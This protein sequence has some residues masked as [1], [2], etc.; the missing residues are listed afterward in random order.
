[1]DEQFVIGLEFEADFAGLGELI[2]VVLELVSR[3]RE[4]RPRQQEENRQSGWRSNESC[5]ASCG[6]HIGVAGS[7]CKVASRLIY[8]GRIRCNITSSYGA[9]LDGR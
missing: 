1:M 7:L 6:W 8:D 3:E 9:W 2:R 5:F 4:L